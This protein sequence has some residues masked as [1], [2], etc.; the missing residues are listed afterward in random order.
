MT[1]APAMHIPITSHRSGSVS[2]R[3][4]SPVAIRP[5]SATVGIATAPADPTDRGPRSVTARTGVCSYIWPAYEPRRGG[6]T[7]RGKRRGPGYVHRGFERNTPS[8]PVGAAV[9][10]E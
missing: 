7:V 10:V 2:W 4:V 6:E 8:G 9:A 5:A 1:I 3:L